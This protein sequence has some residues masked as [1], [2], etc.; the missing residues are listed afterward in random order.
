MNKQISIFFF[1]TLLSLS[2]FGKSGPQKAAC[3]QIKEICLKAGFSKGA[4][5]LGVGLKSHCI[6]PIISGSAA[7]GS[8]LPLPQI[9]SKLVEKC[10]RENPAFGKPKG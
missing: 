5:G 9:S 1:M 3:E 2:S 7:K 10:K 4:S 6:W 8:K